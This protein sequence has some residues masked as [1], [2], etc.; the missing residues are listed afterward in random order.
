[1][2]DRELERA[3][4]IIP[5]VLDRATG[6]GHTP[7]SAPDLVNALQSEGI[8]EEAA[9]LAM[10]YLIDRGVIGL[11]SDWRVQL[12]PVDVFVP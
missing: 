9:R 7:L 8:G 5:A 3:S 4:E 2:Q 12:R 11:T 6:D 1:M 10:W